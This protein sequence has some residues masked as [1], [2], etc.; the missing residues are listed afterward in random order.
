MHRV[1]QIDIF[2]DLTF[3]HDKDSRFPLEGKHARPPAAVVTPQR[4]DNGT[5]FVRYRP[6]ELACGSCHTDYHQGQFLE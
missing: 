2:A 1:P 3:D 4:V 5:S 6:L